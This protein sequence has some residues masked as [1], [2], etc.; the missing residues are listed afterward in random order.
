MLHAAIDGA[1]RCRDCG[2][3]ARLD[4]FSRWVVSIMIAITLPGVLLYGDVFYSGHLFV[5][6]MII[7]F[8]AWRGMSWLGLPFF[9][10]EAAEGQSPLRPSQ[11]IFIVSLLLV[12]ALVIDVFMASRFDAVAAEDQPLAQRG[13]K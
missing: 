5:I 3:L 2:R 6:S 13:L 12:A 9:G 1:M 8:T 7:I 4:L 10:L 11:S